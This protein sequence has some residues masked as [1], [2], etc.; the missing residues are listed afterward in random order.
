MSSS[1]TPQHANVGAEIPDMALKQADGKPITLKQLA[2]HDGTLIGF[3]HG[4][5][6]PHCVQQ[7]AR[8]NRVAERLAEHGIKLV[9]VLAD[10]PTSIS[11]Y[12][13]AASPSPRFEM[14]PDTEPS[15]TTQ[16]GVPPEVTQ[17]QPAPFAFILDAQN[18]VR[19]VDH[20][21]NPHAPLDVDRLLAALE[22]H[23]PHTA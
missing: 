6:C 22:D 4:T 9:W 23:T 20:R 15:I 7:L 14:L 3:M 18:H 11:A 16:F 12:Q 8:S 10:K 17:H 19:Y 5:Y 2:G 1:E 13:I 21:D